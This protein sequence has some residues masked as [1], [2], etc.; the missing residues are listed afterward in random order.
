VAV[1]I[2]HIFYKLKPKGRAIPLPTWRG[3]EGSRRLKFS[4]FKLYVP[5]AFIPQEISLVLTSVRV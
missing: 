1:F 4:D 2:I 3:P 5:A